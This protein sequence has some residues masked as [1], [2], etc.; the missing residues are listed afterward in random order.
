MSA[1]RHWRQVTP[2][3]VDCASQM[4]FLFAFG[5]P[6]KRFNPTRSGSRGVSVR[7]ILVSGGPP[8]LPSVATVG[9][10][11]DEVRVRAEPGT[12]GVARHDAD[13]H[14]SMG[15]DSKMAG[16]ARGIKALRGAPRSAEISAQSVLD[17][18]GVVPDHMRGP[19]RRYGY[20]R[21]VLPMLFGK[22]RP[23]PRFANI[24]ADAHGDADPCHDLRI[25]LQLD[26]VRVPSGA[27]DRLTSEFPAAPSAVLPTSTGV[28]L[29]P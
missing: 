19:V 18:P 5:I 9:A 17:A 14:I 15:S 7:P 1:T 11:D 23:A 22:R 24:H 13:R 6:G 25:E 3:S 12:S 28:Q 4:P 27:T 26:E 20:P 21:T 2:L 29:S 16:A 10:D 8:L